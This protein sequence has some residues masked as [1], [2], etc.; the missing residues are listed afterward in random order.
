MLDLAFDAVN[1]YGIDKIK[2]SVV[3]TEE[4]KSEESQN[5]ETTENI[6]G[7]QVVTEEPSAEETTEVS[8]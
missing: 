8:E 2:E 7:N 5:T 1:K 6:E 3:S 4:N